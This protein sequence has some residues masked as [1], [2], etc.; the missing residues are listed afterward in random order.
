[1][2]SAHL[3]EGIQAKALDQRT[4]ELRLPEPRS[5]VAYLLALFGLFPWP[6]H[7]VESLGE[8]WLAGGNVVGNGPFRIAE[9]AQESDLWVA[10]PFWNGSRGNVREI[11]FGHRHSDEALDEWERGRLRPPV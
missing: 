6:R 11:V 1:M 5:R 8:D 4:L 7:V 10:S 2:P 9:V 3:L